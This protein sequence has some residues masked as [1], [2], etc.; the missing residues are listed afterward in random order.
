MER[1]EVISGA[2]TIRQLDRRLW[3]L[4]EILYPKSCGPWVVEDVE[5]DEIDRGLDA[6]ELH[7]LATVGNWAVLGW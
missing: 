1:R 6:D 3:Q 2:G 4:D 5:V 7:V